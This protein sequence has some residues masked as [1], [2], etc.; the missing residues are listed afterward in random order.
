MRYRGSGSKGVFLGSLV[1]IAAACAPG[2]TTPAAPAP[3][4]TATV[5]AQ[6]A[7]QALGANLVTGVLREVSGSSLVLQGP[8]S[9]TVN[10]T[11]APDA[12][13]L[14]Q[15]LTS[16]ADL[17]VGEQITF[18]GLRDSTGAM[19]A[20]VVRV[21]PQS[22]G[23]LTAG[24]F[25]GPVDASGGQFVPRAGAGAGAGAFG[26]GQSGQG[27]GQG[28]RPGSRTPGELTI[29]GPIESV[30]SDALMVTSASVTYTVRLAENGQVIRIATVP[31]SEL[32]PGLRITG[33]GEQTNG[34]WTLTFVL[35]VEEPR[36]PGRAP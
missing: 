24:L 28:Q 3:T 7:A 11:L 21:V 26:Q 27:A 17:R 1:L 32:Q 13:I 16:F 25:A 29:T 33:R 5:A 9:G 15:S 12:T 34:A 23:E 14:K 36:A 19:L 4:G 31:P 30:Q 22:L 35:L 20:S 10:A 2:T 8:Q 18:V 6:R